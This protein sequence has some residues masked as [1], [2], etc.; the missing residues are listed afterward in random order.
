MRRLIG[1]EEA[2]FHCRHHACHARIELVV[3]GENSA[4][5]PARVPSADRRRL[6]R[7]TTPLNS[8]ASACLTRA[9]DIVSLAQTGVRNLCDG[10][11]ERLQRLLDKEWK[12]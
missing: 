2:R 5:P 8:W 6:H 10:S 11:R 3:L 1:S 12:C 7:P 9:R 4:A